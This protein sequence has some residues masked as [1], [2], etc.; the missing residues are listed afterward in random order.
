MAASIWVAVST[1]QASS[2]SWRVD[3]SAQVVRPNAAC[4]AGSARRT[5]SMSATPTAP[6]RMP[7]KQSYSLSMGVCFTVF[8]GIRSQLRMGA[9]RSRARSFAPSA[10]RLARGVARLS[11]RDAVDWSMVGNLLERT[12]RQCLP[13]FTTFLLFLV[14]P[15]TLPFPAFCPR[16]DGNAWWFSPLVAPA[17]PFSRSGENWV[18]RANL[19]HVFLVDAQL[20]GAVLDSAI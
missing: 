15:P 13:R 9:N 8:C 5:R 4:S 16:R 14:Q 3:C 10:A 2:V 17:H 12:D 19:R 6:A 18:T 7:I 20:S 1:V 11:S